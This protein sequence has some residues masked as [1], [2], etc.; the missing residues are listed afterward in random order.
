MDNTRNKK[1]NNRPEAPGRD[2]AAG[3][4][5]KII[6]WYPGHMAK[7]GR[8]LEE[9]LK[10]VNVVIELCDA[11]LP[12]SS[13]NPKIDRIIGGK[14]RI[15]VFNKADLADKA[16]SDYWM[17][18][19]ASKGYTVVFTDSRSGDGVKKVVK[20]VRDVKEEKIQRGREKGRIITTIYCMVVGIPNVG[21][22]SFVNRVTGRS[23]AVTGDRPGVTREKQWL[24]MDDSVYLLDTPGL[25]WPRIENQMSAM[26]LAACG[27]IKDEVVDTGELAAFLLAYLEE[28]YPGAL[29]ARYAIDAAEIEAGDE[30]DY[31]SGSILGNERLRRGLALLEA[32]GRSRG[33]LVKGGEVDLTRAAAIVLDEF[34]GGKIGAISLDHPGVIEEN[35]RIMLQNREN[36][37]MK[38][39]KRAARKAQYRRKRK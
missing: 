33:C 38:Q 31:V 30:L 22:S 28:R 18:Y 19:Y 39:Q 8:T 26:R 36:D 29:K 37:E 25:L 13:R 7:A 11:R 1:T 9:N 4:N 34:R 32:C 5:G 3:F 27:A 14:P 35:E 21:K 16:V 12:F 24:K 17:S 10:L 2:D 20:A 6:N 15:L 23:A